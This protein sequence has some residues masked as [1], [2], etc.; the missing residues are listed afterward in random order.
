MRVIESSGLGLLE[1]LGPRLI[2]GEDGEGL[3]GDE[4]VWEVMNTC[5]DPR[6][7]LQS[8]LPSV[9][10]E[11]KSLPMLVVSLSDAQ[12]RRVRLWMHAR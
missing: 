1:L 9:L 7:W 10:H 6:A 8:V 4:H 12:V 5:G 2:S 11:G 3:G